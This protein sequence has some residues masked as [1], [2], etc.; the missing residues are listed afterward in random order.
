MSINSLLKSRFFYSW[1]LPL[2]CAMNA[3]PAVLKSCLES[4]R[5]YLSIKY[6]GFRLY[7]SCPLSKSSLYSLQLHLPNSD[8]QISV[9]LPYLSDQKKKETHKNPPTIAK[10]WKCN[11]S[12][13]CTVYITAPCNC[14]SPLAFVLCPLFFPLVFWLPQ[15]Y[16]Y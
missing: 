14:L 5:V 11:K 6:H 8:W 10:T 3:S 9:L 7:F 2:F 13:P 4:L 15:H 1:H 16:Y 12:L